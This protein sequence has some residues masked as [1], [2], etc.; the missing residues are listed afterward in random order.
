[1]KRNNKLLCIYELFFLMFI[2]LYRF[3]VI[4]KYI[5][6]SVY[7]SLSFWAIFII[8]LII[9]GGFPKDKHFLKKTSIRI[10][11]IVLLLYFIIA[12]ILGFFL[13]FYKTAYAHDFVSIIKNVVP[14]ALH[15]VGIEIGRYL[16]LRK[17]TNKWHLGV[18]TIL[19]ILYTLNITMP[20]I[21]NFNNAE[22]VFLTLSLI[23]LPVISRELLFMYMTKNVSFAPSLLYHVLMDTYSMVIPVL[24]DLG[25][26]ISSVVLVFLPYITYK[27]I[28]KGLNIKE[29]Y[30][31]Y[32]KK[33]VARIL[34]ITLFIFFLTLIILISGIF[35]YKMVAIASDSMNPIYYRGDAVIYKKVK[36]SEVKEGDI[37][38]F[39]VDRVLVTHRVKK[40]MSDKNG[41]YFITKGDNNDSVDNYDVREGNVVGV[42]KH[43][44][45]YIAFPTVWFSDYTEEVD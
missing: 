10:V 37:L 26:Y 25:N 14:V 8:S 20:V 9:I 11:F 28:K 33:V 19:F 35:N 6:Y 13:G 15:I 21:P 2:L 30:A 40:I 27:Q 17:D 16:I 32:G 34:S 12:G 22:T 1:M 42:V 39:Q 45:K 23:I 29:K 41:I 4:K 5:A 38:A 7:I 36:A 31:K 43:V 18:L 3:I 24:P 44:V